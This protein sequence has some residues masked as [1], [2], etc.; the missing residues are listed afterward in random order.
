MNDLGYGKHKRV[1]YKSRTKICFVALH[2]SEFGVFWEL[3]L[4]GVL[5]SE[6]VPP[7][8]FYFQ[9]DIILPITTN[10]I[11]RFRCRCSTARTLHLL[12]SADVILKH[13]ITAILDWFRDD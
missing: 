12:D 9:S 7:A 4:H 13:E 5:E 8:E 6:T 11:I 1:D 2:C 10:T 3:R